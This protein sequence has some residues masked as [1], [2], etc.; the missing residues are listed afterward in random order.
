MR[1]TN[2]PG[3][4]VAGAACQSART[5]T[6]PCV[7]ISVGRSFRVV[8]SFDALLQEVPEEWVEEGLALGLLDEEGAYWPLQTVGR[9]ESVPPEGR[10]RSIVPGEV[11]VGVPL[12]DGMERAKQELCDILDHAPEEAFREAHARELFRGCVRSAHD[13]VD[14]LEV[15]GAIGLVR[16]L[17]RATSWPP[18]LGAALDRFPLDA[19][20]DPTGPSPLG[21]GRA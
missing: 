6:F 12:A 16:D 21:S 14:L 9:S 17:Y 5:L 15:V 18:S 10:L 7:A 11:T 1:R 2:Q 3:N 19:M 4:G 20:E 13:P 8:D